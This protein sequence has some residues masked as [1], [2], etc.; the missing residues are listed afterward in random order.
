MSR[1]GALED[2]VPVFTRLSRIPACAAHRQSIAPKPLGKTYMSLLDEMPMS[3]IRPLCIF[4][5]GMLTTCASSSRL[6]SDSTAVIVSQTLP[7]AGTIANSDFSTYRI[8]PL[9][10]LSIDVFG[11]P[12]LSR[13]GAVDIAGN[14][15]MPLIGSVAAGGL[16]PLQL[17]DR[18]TAALR[19]RYVKKP[20]VSVNL[21]QTRPRSVT[22]D[23]AVRSPGSFPVVGIMT[24]QEAIAQAKGANDLA[25]LRNVV[26]FRSVGAK[27]WAAMF[28]LRQIRS[29]RVA[30]PRVFADDV[31]IVGEDATRRF[32]KDLS[33]SFPP[34]GSFVPVL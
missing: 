14:F 24:L 20:E 25:D 10:T 9:D 22:V 30:D 33:A 1:L 19:A 34:F 32:F 3:P 11:A 16:T 7:T 18:I 29:G 21:T 8:G 26:V 27:K 6:S 31:V 5:F 17:G 4:C 23:G 13:S 12:E 28:D 2:H 15:S